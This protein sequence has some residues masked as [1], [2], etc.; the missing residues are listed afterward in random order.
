M[1]GSI[2]ISFLMS[3]RNWS[4]LQ[5]RLVF[6]LE[7]KEFLQQGLH[8]V[9][10]AVAEVLVLLASSYDGNIIHHVEELV[11]D[12][13]ELVGEGPGLMESPSWDE[14]LEYSKF[15]RQGSSV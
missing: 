15:L 10:L 2:L 11:V 12:I 9:P 1:C 14:I 7:I 6:M 4:W 8:H 13:K 5:L 3:V